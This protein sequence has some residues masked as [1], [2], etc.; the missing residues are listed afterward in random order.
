MF[1][2][3]PCAT[4][5]PQN[6]SKN[7]RSA[8]FVQ[9]FELVMAKNDGSPSKE[10]SEVNGDDESLSGDLVRV[11]GL[12]WGGTVNITFEHPSGVYLSR[13]SR[14]GY[15][16]FEFAGIIRFL[17]H[18]EVPCDR[19]WLEYDG[20]PLK[21]HVPVGALYDHLYLPGGG[22]RDE[23]RVQIHTDEYPEGVI[24]YKEEIVQQVVLNQLKQLCFVVN[25][26]AKN[27]MALSEELSRQWWA[28]I[29]HRNYPTY[30]S[31]S[32]R[33]F[34]KCLRVPIKLVVPGLSNAIQAPAAPRPGEKET[35]LGD[36]LEK[37]VPGLEGDPI[38]HGITVSR[39]IPVLT[40]WQVFR[41]LDGMLYLSVAVAK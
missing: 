32:R 21:W 15:L 3:G 4:R 11:R 10:G 20:V 23:W 26:T 40:A 25:G 22:D 2:A 29:V 17:R 19:L 35:T 37:Y 30:T 38:L 36:V 16:A 34:T 1:H 6:I 39:A 41:H 18:H 27:I 24:Q 28:A 5:A 13:C 9:D 8:P 33:V 14:M 7:T 12:V 31:I